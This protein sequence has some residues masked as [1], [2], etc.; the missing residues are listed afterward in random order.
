MMR[1]QVGLEW[2]K[3]YG[4]DKIRVLTFEKNRGKGGAVRM[5]R[6]EMLLE[7]ESAWSTE[8]FKTFPNHFE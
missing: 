7:K 4:A 8:I 3:K 6:S 2:S 5:V 1:F